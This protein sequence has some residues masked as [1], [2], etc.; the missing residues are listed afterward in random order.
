MHDPRLH[1]VTCYCM[2]Q[3]VRDAE[4]KDESALSGGLFEAAARPLRGGRTL[5]A[6]WCLIGVR[7]LEPLA[8]RSRTERG[9]GHSVMP[10]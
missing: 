6:R 9:P 8:S 7:L 10:G 2:V 5:S 1:L 3:Y 4:Q